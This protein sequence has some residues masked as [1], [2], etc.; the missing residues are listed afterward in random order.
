[1]T[2]NCSVCSQEYIPVPVTAP[3]ILKEIG[4]FSAL[5]LFIKET[6][7]LFFFFKMKWKM[8]HYKGGMKRV[9]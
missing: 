4:N 7:S 2:T 1:M 3:S 5:N 6:K 8:S 9:F